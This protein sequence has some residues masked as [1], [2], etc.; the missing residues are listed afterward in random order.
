PLVNTQQKQTDSIHV[1][2]KQWGKWLTKGIKVT[3]K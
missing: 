2:S 3:N 1:Y